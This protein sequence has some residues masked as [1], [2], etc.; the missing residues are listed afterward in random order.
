MTREFAETVALRALGWLV[1]NQELLPV[2][3]G[4]TGMSIEDLRGSAGEPDVLISVLD[5]LCLD[6]AWVL[7]F[8]AEGNLPPESLMQAREALPGG[9][10]V[11]WT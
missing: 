7:E 4:S 9:A 8:S 5:F 2:F 6:D 3:L 11:H 10:R 1:G